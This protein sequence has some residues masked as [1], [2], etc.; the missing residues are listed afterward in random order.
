LGQ[1]GFLRVA[2]SFLKIDVT[3][4]VIHEADKP[5]PFIDILETE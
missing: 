5:N 4:I 2:E 1:K 3:Q